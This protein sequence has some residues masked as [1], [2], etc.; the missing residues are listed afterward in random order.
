M[1]RSA[2]NNSN[3]TLKNFH[4]CNLFTPPKSHSFALD[5]GTTHHFGTTHQLNETQLPCTTASATLPNNKQI[6][7]THQ[8]N[9]KLNLPPEATKCCILPNLHT[10][11]LSVGQFCYADCTTIFLDRKAHV[12]KNNINISSHLNSLINNSDHALTTTR[13]QTNGLHI[14]QDAP[15]NP[16]PLVLPQ[17]NLAHHLHPYRF[18]NHIHHFPTTTPQL[19]NNLCKMHSKYERLRCL[20]AACDSPVKSTF[21]KA[22]RNGNFVGWPDLNSKDVSKY[23]QQEDASLKGHLHRQ[24]KNLQS[25]KPRSDSSDPEPPIIHTQSTA[26]TKEV[27]CKVHAG[28]MF[29]DLCGKF[30][31][32][33][34]KNNRYIIVFFHCNTNSITPRAS[35]SRSDSDVQPIFQD[36]INLLRK[37]A[38]R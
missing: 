2:H 8:V 26:A 30:P 37:K 16:S 24:R 7:S 22:I 34:S 14:A 18:I 10:S 29:E 23:L 38:T 35:K 9:L 19:I 13:D 3:T 28:T 20:C 31:A 12:L 15:P 25:T 6:Q 36:I 21:L 11:L 4:M 33:S 27:H 17:L 1:D 32:R 5:S